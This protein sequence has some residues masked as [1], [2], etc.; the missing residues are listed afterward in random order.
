MSVQ[1]TV[2]PISTIFVEGTLLYCKSV[3]GE[4]GGRAGEIGNP[5]ELS[6]LRASYFDGIDIEE[7]KNDCPIVTE[8]SFSSEYKFMAT[9]YKPTAADK[10]PAGTY[11]DRM[12]KFF[13]NQAKGGVM[14]DDNL[15]PI[16]DDYWLSKL[17]SSAPAVYVSLVL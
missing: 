10:A 13:K 2:T 5:T 3:L 4:G 15:E 6:I 14:G 11:T 1:E 12:V 8:V 17:P 9:I 16:N 7:L